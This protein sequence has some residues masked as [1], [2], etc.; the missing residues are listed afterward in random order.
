[1]NARRL[2]L[3]V[4]ATTLGA[5][6]FM[7]APALAVI[8]PVVTIKAVGT[9]TSTTAKVSGTVDPNGSPTTTAWDFQYSK[10]P[11]TEGWTP[12]VSGIAVAAEEV[13]GTIEGLQPSAS[14]QVRLVAANEEGGEGV[15]AEPNPKLKTGPL[16]PEIEGESVVGV[17]PVEA[18]L[19]ALVNA[20][21]QVTECH[22]QYGTEPSLATST[23]LPCEQATIEGY[24]TQGVALS[25]PGLTQATTYYYRVIA[26]NV[27]HEKQEGAIEHFTTGTPEPPEASKVIPV[28]N[29]TATLKGVLNPR[30]TGEGGT[31]EFV[32]RKS[33]GECQ[34]GEPGEEK[35]APEPAGKANG[36][37]GE[38]EEAP[39][40]G[41]EPGTT[42][43]FCLL[44]KNTTEEPALSTPVT[45]TTI[46]VLPTITGEF[47]TG[48][49]A[50]VATLNAS[51]DPGGAS[52]TYHFEYLTEAQ[53]NANGETFAGAATTPESEPVGVDNIE[54]PA[55]ASLTGLQ[56]GTT[57]HYHA[58]ATNSQSLTGTHGAD[59]TFTTPTE[60]GSTAESCSNAK[61]RTEQ[62]YGS[63]LPDCRAYEMV[64]PLAK[65]GSDIFFSGSRASVPLPG[66]P[67]AFTYLSPGSF[68]GPQGAGELSRYLTR[69]EPTGWSV[70]NISPPRVILGTEAF[71][72]FEQLL[73]T[74][75]LSEGVERSPYVPLVE[76]DE[77]GYINLYLSDLT[78]S[79]V[80]Y[81]TVSNVNPPGV[82]P[83][84]ETGAQTEVPVAAGVSTDLSHVVFQSGANLTE[85]ATGEEEQKTH[86]YEWAAGKLSQL[87]ISP[88]GT[89]FE[90]FDTVGA[91][92]HSGNPREGD[93]WH[94]VSADGQ[95]VFFTAGEGKG[96]EG[97][98]VGQ[99]YVRE[100][101]M[102][103][104]EDCS[105]SG[106]ACTVEVSKSQK[107]N[108]TGPDGTDPNSYGE[109]FAGSGKFEI[110]PGG[111][112]MP[113]YYRGANEAGTR[114][115]FTSRA[116]LT[117]DAYTGPKDNSANLYEYNV[118]TGTLTD[119]TVDNAEDGAA[120]LGLATASEDGS[121][122]YF[123]ANGV[124]A[125]G[126]KQGNCKMEENE[127]L[128]GEHTCSLY[129]DHYSGGKWEIKFITML[130]GGDHSTLPVGDET[131]W[132]DYEAGANGSLGSDFGPGQH[133]VRVT[134]D[135]TTLA[136]ESE[137]SL[138]GYDNEPVEPGGVG[139][140]TTN[141]PH[142]TEEGGKL[143]STSP[144]VPC[145]EVYLYD[146][147]T[148]KL[149]CA[150]CDPSGARPV[151]PAELG[152]TER[153]PTSMASVSP[154]YLPRNL[155]EGGGRL[156]FQSLDPLVSHDSNGKL[157]VYEWEAAGEG[158][159]GQ[160]G[161]CVYPISDVAGNHESH[162]MDAS[163]SGNDV[164]LATADQLLP[165]D[166]DTRVDVYDARVGGGFPVSTPPPVCDNG[167]SCKP[168]VLPQPS[169]F[170]ASGSATFSGLGNP[171]PPPP[172]VKSKPTTKTVKCK[173]PKKLSHGKC[174]KKNRK[175][176]QQAK[177]PNRRAH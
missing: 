140:T 107:T 5:L 30:H 29:T 104:V 123:V 25:V 149:V 142:C 154:F 84:R 126:A 132:A 90:H 80:S 118:E 24:P 122:L 85:K 94:A 41:L 49:E 109:Y 77:A 66:E 136:F 158:S 87:D 27:A 170:A 156:F 173:K 32:Y 165:S 68:S 129:V 119:L 34:G 60:P 7:A 101:P 124:L 19:E 96:N 166:T 17:T 153:D 55:L 174:T 169:I 58:V 150:S 102:G 53:F 79:P 144:A 42:Y 89:Q 38:A 168:P 8:S 40:T 50:T 75:S 31:Y 9:V 61:A 82:T 159:C 145:R 33:P 103:P 43:T 26:E 4:L 130:T 93:P 172:V 10:D 28:T 115:F 45:F 146:A 63:T 152:G 127:V 21:N 99:L 171:A 164:F 16:P 1:M 98:S 54:H 39:V 36:V 20:N 116:E 51:I 163:P 72:P 12:A 78:S 57:Y 176:P 44:A 125:S 157:D 112:P 3:S 100:D 86:I 18:R 121:Y 47:T 160:A 143:G 167:D 110:I 108:G 134:P 73:F 111:P 74:P 151:A 139:S 46:A 62:P 133:S 91:P 35:K 155:S 59:A 56:P 177:K 106:D 92:G 138:T 113:V 67:Q 83:Y 76:S 88:A 81:Q 70:E 114:V 15:S 13:T 147:V 52:T 137:R 135:G 69:R 95:R 23:T 14:Y 141:E 71:P 48:V 65:N 148:E 161:G 37:Q 120:V 2:T 175:K 131:D 22:F 64:S 11:E 6:V 97:T 162:F 117:N 128:T 105:V